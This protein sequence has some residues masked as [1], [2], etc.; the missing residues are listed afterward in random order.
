MVD[1]QLHGLALYTG[2]ERT[3]AHLFFCWDNASSGYHNDLVDKRDW[4]HYVIYLCT[5]LRNENCK[6]YSR[7]KKVA[8]MR[9][10]LY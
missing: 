8:S 1:I 5:S 2:K 9:N 4:S 6:S 10:Q 3:R 7:S